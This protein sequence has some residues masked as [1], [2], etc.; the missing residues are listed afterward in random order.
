M[1]TLLI[2]FLIFFIMGFC[3]ALGRTFSFKDPISYFEEM[4]VKIINKL[5]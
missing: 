2:I 3:I 1:I 5:K 4:W